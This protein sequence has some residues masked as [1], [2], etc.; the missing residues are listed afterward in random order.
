MTAHRAHR[1]AGGCR[2]GVIRFAADFTETLQGKPPRA[3]DCDY[4]TRH[5][6]AYL[7]DPRGRLVITLT[8]PAQVGHEHQGSGI[9]DFWICRECGVL[10]V[11][12]YEER[13]RVY[14]TVNAL[15]LDDADILAPARTVSPQQLDDPER[16]ARWKSL[17]FN[18]VEIVQE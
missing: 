12:T 2:C 3:C 9:A 7:S 16:V 8:D 18:D 1:Y 15:A 14:A 10:A 13:G 4:C 17:W 6:A 11:T 5:G